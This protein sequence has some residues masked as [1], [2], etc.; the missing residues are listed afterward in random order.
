LRLQDEGADVLVSDIGMPD[1]DGFALIRRVRQLPGE[2]GR[3]PAVALTAY[4]RP[5]DRQ[6]AIEAGF[7]VHLPKPVEIPALLSSLATL[8]QRAPV[9]NAT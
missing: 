9:P 6:H 1:V 5:E 8:T 4:A 2:V 7:Q 3:L